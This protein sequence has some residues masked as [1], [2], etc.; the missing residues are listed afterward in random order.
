MDSNAKHTILIV[1][2]DKFLL[3]MYQTKFGKAGWTV[4][5]SL[6]A[7]EALQKLRDGLQPSAI[8]F[9]IIMPGVDGVEFLSLLKKEKLAP[10]AALIALTNQGKEDG[11]IEKVKVLGVDGYIVK[12]A[13]IPSEVVEMVQRIV[14]GR[15]K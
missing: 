10:R 3:A 4:E 1:D 9:D 11:S 6:N 12:A 2:D 7:T 8:M 15:K 13:L 5:A 14:D